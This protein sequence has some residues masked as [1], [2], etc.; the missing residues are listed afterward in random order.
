M[1]GWKEKVKKNKGEHMLRKSL[2]SI[3]IIYSTLFATDAKAA[4]AKAIDDLARAK[5]SVATPPS[6]V[7]AAADQP[8]TKIGALLATPQPAKPANK[9]LAFRAMTYN[10]CNPAEVQRDPELFKK[11]SWSSRKEK[12]FKQILEESPDFIGFQEVRNEE[13]GSS[14]ADIWAGL[15]KHGYEIVSFRNNPHDLSMINTVGY[16]AKSFVL[17]KTHRWWASETPEQFSDSWGNG[18]GRVVL[19]GTF[20]SIVEQNVRGQKVPHPDYAQLPIHFVNLHNGL[21]HVERMNSNRVHVQQIEKL[22]GS[23]ECVVVV[24]GDFNC[25]PDDG[26][27]EELKIWTDAGYKEALCD[28]K[29]GNGVP[30]SGTFLGYS[31]DKFK[32]PKGKLGAQLDHIYVKVFSKKHAAK[33]ASHVNLN[34]HDGSAD[35]KAKSESEL[36]IAPDGTDLRDSAFEQIADRRLVFVEDFDQLALRVALGTYVF[37]NRG[38]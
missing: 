35:A 34:R 2:L 8:L 24:T 9:Q 31:Y 23:E 12:I 28:L 29:T 15:G 6:G 33:F 27:V 38:E 21:K 19:M 13:G 17:D 32:A 37:E 4:Q 18:W 30:V 1:S 26:G 36:L 7:K 20:R 10:V 11:F 5:S 3:I 25:F 22:V 16:K 14:V